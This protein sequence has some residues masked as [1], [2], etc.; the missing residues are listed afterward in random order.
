MGRL[1]QQFVEPPRGCSY[2]S[3]RIAAL[4]Y[5]LMIDVGPPEVEA[6]LERG[7]RRFGPAYFR[8]ACS[9]CGE[10]R[11]LRVPVASFAPTRN[12]R[13][14]LG[15]GEALRVEVGPVRVDGERLA[16]YAAWHASREQARNWEPSAM[17]EDD[18]ASQF[19]FPHPCA[20]EIAY[21][22]DSSVGGGGAPR[23]VG[24]GLY[25]Q[26]PRAISAIYFFYDPAYARSSPGTFHVLTLLGLA[27]QHGQAHVYLGYRISD[28][29]SMRY[30]ALFH[31]HE[32]L[33][34]RPGASETPRWVT[35]DADADEATAG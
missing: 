19:G 8:P 24:V 26:T 30:K 31:P 10:C 1:L 2:L 29:P 16:L 11:S 12:Q 9:P 35:A 33:V 7:W 5:R 22:D 23:L 18:Y 17:D 3:D 6:M 34:G 14:A 27:A 15:K 4:E 32:L 21:Y 25:D 20:R 28:C 13:R